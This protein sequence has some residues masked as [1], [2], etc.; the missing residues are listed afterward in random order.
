MEQKDDRADRIAL[1]ISRLQEEEAHKRM[2]YDKSIGGPMVLRPSDDFIRQN[3][4]E[5][6]TEKQIEAEAIQQVDKKIAQEQAI[7]QERTEWERINEKHVQRLE[8]ENQER[9]KLEKLAERSQKNREELR[10]R[11][12]FIERMMEHQKK[13][14][15]REI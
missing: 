6:K 12:S 7:A 14:D 5:L 15:E 4:G 1:E 3:V 10:N 2:L 9:S 8:K 13:K 11:P